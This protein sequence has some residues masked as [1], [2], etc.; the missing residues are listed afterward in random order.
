MSLT[1][2]KV[3]FISGLIFIFASFYYLTRI[4]FTDTVWFGGDSWE[5][6]VMAVNWAK[7]YPLMTIGAFGDYIQDYHFEPLISEDY[8]SLFSSFIAAGQSGGFDNF[9]RTPGYPF[10]LGL[11]Y[12][13][14]GVSPQLAQQIQLLL[15]IAAAT[16]LPWFGF[17]YWQ[18]LGFWSGLVGAGLYL[19]TYAKTLPQSSGLTYPN[20][21]MTENLI[22]FGLAIFVASYIF[23]EKTR[24]PIRSIFLGAILGLNLLIKG[25]VVFIPFLIFLY[26]FYLVCRRRLAWQNLLGLLLGIVIVILPWSAYASFKSSQPII[27]STQGQAVLFFGNNE[28][29]ADGSWHPE[30]YDSSNPQAFYNQPEIKDL[31]VPQKLLVFYSHHRDLLPQIFFARIRSGFYSFPFFIASILLISWELLRQTF[32]PV[33]RHL[34]LITFIL[35]SSLFYLYLIQ[36]LSLFEFLK[37]LLPVNRVLGGFVLMFSLSWLIKKQPPRLDLPPV[38]LI[39][40]FNFLLLTLITFGF[41]RFIQVIDFVFMLVFAKYALT[42]LRELF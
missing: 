29:G 32:P 4:K 14:F 23:W 2:Y 5:Y 1:N 7:G 28:Y 41:A 39:L 20:Q 25:C 35:T 21:L 13:L 3:F 6:Q 9:Y 18:R 38:F 30:G 26:W 15:I 42:L 8:Q 31:P 22:V 34:R 24:R 11:I 40:F 37:A 36:D 27:L 12:R 19:L 17:V 33:K 16:T 10:F